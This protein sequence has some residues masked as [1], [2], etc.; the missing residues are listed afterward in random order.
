MTQ[1]A[2]H[3]QENIMNDLRNEI[4]VGDI[5]EI[6]TISSIVAKTVKVFGLTRFDNGSIS[7]EGHRI[8]KNGRV[9]YVQGFFISPVSQVLSVTKDA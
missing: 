5:I 7:I 2:T 3:T 1:T 8:F 4:E 9:T 6:R